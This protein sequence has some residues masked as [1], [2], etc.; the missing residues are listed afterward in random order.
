MSDDKPIT[1]ITTKAPAFAFLRADGTQHIYT[2]KLPPVDAD[3]YAAMKER[4]EAAERERGQLRGKYTTLIAETSETLQL[5]YQVYRDAGGK[6]NG[7]SIFSLG[8]WLLW[9]PTQKDELLDPQPRA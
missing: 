9:L 8:E 5:A 1:W 6:V 7:N 4:A 2:C 3:L